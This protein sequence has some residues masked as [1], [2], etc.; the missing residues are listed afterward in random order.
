[1]TGLLRKRWHAEFKSSRA[2]SAS[3]ESSS[4]SR[5]LPTCTAVIPVYPRCSSALWTVLP[6]GSSTARLG[7]II[8]LAFMQHER[9][10]EC[11][12]CD[13]EFQRSARRFL[14]GEIH[15]ATR[16]QHSF[17][18]ELRFLVH[19][20][21]SLSRPFNLRDRLACGKSG[22]RKVTHLSSRPRCDLAIQMQ[23]DVGIF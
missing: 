9:S 10:N 22:S 23:L 4:I 18:R 14:P 13:G 8:I 17:M 2:F 7:V 11:P 16:V 5:Y 20:C 6:C 19:A 3:F 12:L 15:I 21:Q 1:M